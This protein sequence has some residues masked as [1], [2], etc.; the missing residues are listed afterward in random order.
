MSTLNS[1]C[2]DSFYKVPLIIIGSM[3]GVAAFACL[4]AA[5][6]LCALKLHNK[7]VYRLILYQVLAGLGLSAVFVGQLFLIKYNELSTVVEGAY[8]GLCTAFAFFLTY[9]EW[10]KLVFTVWVTFHL[11]CFAVFFINLRSRFEPMYVVT[12]MLIPAI[13]SCVPLATGKY[14]PAELWCWIKD[15]DCHS[16]TRDSAA[17]IEQFAL[18][19]GPCMAVL[20]LTVVAMVAMLVIVVHRIYGRLTTLK[21][22]Q[23]WKALKQLLPLAIYPILFLV[24][25][26]MPFVNRLYGSLNSIAESDQTRYGLSISHAV[27]LG[28]WNLST[29]LV[30]IVHVSVAG[31]SRKGKDVHQVGIHGM[32]GAGYRYSS[33]DES[34]VT[35]NNHACSA[36]PS[37]YSTWFA[38]PTPSI[39]N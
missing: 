9:T 14:G 27:S 34:L 26:I 3:N 1:S 10:V 4:I 8:N 25:T 32:Q 21:R 16:S 36:P 24:F 7:S 6:S 20:I 18:W 39:D 29:G 2:N 17:I 35:G 33:M 12:S 5:I 22:D 13:I 15:W 19:F 31:F 23:N 37:D 30:V 28:C 38:L 11:F